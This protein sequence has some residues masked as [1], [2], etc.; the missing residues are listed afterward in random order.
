MAIEKSAYR[1]INVTVKL[2]PAGFELR[3]D[4]FPLTD[5]FMNLLYA[6]VHTLPFLIQEERDLILQVFIMELGF[7]R[8]LS[9]PTATYRL[10]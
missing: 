6:D 8:M 3:G 4:P 1:H 10:P 2:I 9:Y 7:I 5:Q